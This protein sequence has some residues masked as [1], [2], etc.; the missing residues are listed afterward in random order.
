MRLYC[1]GSPSVGCA[2][3]RRP[4]RVRISGSM[5]RPR[6]MC[7]TIRIEA[8]MSRGNSATIR[9]IAST[10]PA[11]APITMTSCLTI[12]PHLLRTEV[13]KPH[14]ITGRA[15][16]VRP[17]AF[18]L[19]REAEG[20][21]HL[22]GL[23]RAHLPIEPGLRVRPEAVSPAQSRTDVGYTQIAHPPDRIVQPVVLEVEP[24][25]QPELGRMLRKLAQRELRRP[26]FA[27]QPHIKVAVIRRSFGFAVPSGRRPRLRQVVQAVPVDAVGT[28]VQ[29]LR[30]SSQ[31][32]LLHLF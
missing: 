20:Q 25:A 7:S 19:G 29:Q 17:H 23:Q 14:D 16:V 26:I 28:P 22:K 21:R 31:P 27:Q 9:L 2:G 18:A 1:S 30:G 13:C 12:S 15:G 24:L 4:A 10:P 3:G 6:E 8:R 11:E 5:L 32:E